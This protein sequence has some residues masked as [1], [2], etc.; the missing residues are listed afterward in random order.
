MSLQAHW[1]R[2][3][4]FQRHFYAAVRR[5]SWYLA[6]DRCEARGPDIKDEPTLQ[7]L[8]KAQ[9]LN[10]DLPKWRL[11]GLPSTLPCVRARSQGFL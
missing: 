10:V 4:S 1:L 3:L 5:L 11:D 6:P 8:R 2:L 7:R 9:C